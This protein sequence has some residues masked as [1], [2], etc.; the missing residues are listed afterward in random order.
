MDGSSS[1]WIIVVSCLVGG[2]FAAVLLIKTLCYCPRRTFSVKNRVVAITGGSSGIGLSVAQECVRK[3][4]HVIL[5]ARKEGPLRQAS[6]ELQALAGG[7]GSSQR[8]LYYSADVTDEQAMKGALEKGAKECGGRIDA[9]VCSAGASLPKEFTATPASDFESQFRL[10]VIG[11]RNAIFNSLPFMNSDDGGRIVIISS[12]AGQVGLY[13]FTAYS[14]REQW[15]QRFREGGL[16][17]TLVFPPHLTPFPSPHTRPT[18]IFFVTAVLQV[19]PQWFGP[20]LGYG[21]GIPEDPGIR[22]LP[23]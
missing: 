11:T 14:V 16:P 9:L 2:V 8:I 23:P 20:G 21:A 18:I 5:L 6:E 10:N 19:C 22:G 13:G 17:C 15:R 12:Q 1:T 3:G 7:V 4:A